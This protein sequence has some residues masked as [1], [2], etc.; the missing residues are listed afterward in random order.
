M[1]QKSLSTLQSINFRSTNSYAG[2]LQL[3]QSVL[4]N[5]QNYWF[6]HFILSEGVLKAIAQ[7][8][9]R[10]FWKG[11]DVPAKGARVIWSSICYP[12]NEGGLGLKDI[13][14]WNKACIVQNI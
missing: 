11:R 13:T 14:S 3:V 9:S 4:F 7:K 8:C 5:I 10:F 12:K 6:R 2:R 1:A